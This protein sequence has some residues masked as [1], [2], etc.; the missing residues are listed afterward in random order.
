[1]VEDFNVFQAVSDYE[2]ICVGIEKGS[3]KNAVL[4]YI[5][6]LM[7]KYN[8]YFRIDDVTHGNKKKIDRIT[9]A[10]QGRLEH[11]RLYLNKGSWNMEFLDQLLQFP[12]PQVHDDLVDAL[13]YIDQIQIPE[14]MQHY[15]EEEFEPLDIVAGY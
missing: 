4:P 13:S 9:W 10:L 6:D 8:R 14:Y 5:S 15:E 7:R 11:G 12:N 3:L 2:P 1:M